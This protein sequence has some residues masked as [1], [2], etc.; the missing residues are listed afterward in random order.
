M[1]M[2]ELKYLH[3]KVHTEIMVKV[4][5][6]FKPLEEDNRKDKPKYDMVHHRISTTV[7]HIF[8][9]SEAHEI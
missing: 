5:V 6:V 9:D 4:C 3:F 8:T 1:R 2:W 7:C